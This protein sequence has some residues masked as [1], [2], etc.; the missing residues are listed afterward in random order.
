[1]IA[2]EILCCMMGGQM[3]IVPCISCSSV[4]PATGFAIG[5]V[6]LGAHADATPVVS[7]E[8]ISSAIGVVDGWDELADTLNP[9]HDVV[10]ASVF[11]A[12][13]PPGARRK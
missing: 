4:A 12:G 3:I 9:S 5:D 2:V 6:I 11:V 8:P 7:V 10:M 13:G 1:M